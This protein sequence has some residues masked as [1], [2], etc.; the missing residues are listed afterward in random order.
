MKTYYASAIVQWQ[1]KNE[2]KPVRWISCGEVSAAKAVGNIISFFEN[3][4]VEPLIAWIEEFECGEKTSIPWMKCYIDTMGYPEKWMR[5]IVDDLM[6][7]EKELTQKRGDG[8]G[9]S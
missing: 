2:E 9:G 7:L 6:L 3:Q 4:N 1:D 5:S 8:N